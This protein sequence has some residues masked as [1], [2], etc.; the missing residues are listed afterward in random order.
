MPQ[1]LEI[2]W[3]EPT[4]ARSREKVARLLDTALDLAVETGSLDF[5]VTDVA[6]R[7]GVAIGTLYQFFPSRAALIARLFAREME[8]I[9]ESISALF[10]GK[11]DLAGLATKV[12]ALMQQQLEWVKARPGLSV[13]WTAPTMHPDIERADFE[14]TRRNA[15]TLAALLSP[16]L[17]ATTT[18][19]AIHATALLICH[20]W[21]SVIR[22]CVLVDDHE[23]ADIIRQYANMI[24]AHGAALASAL[25]E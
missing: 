5:K 2:V 20:L 1:D 15:A 19:E 17:P 25:G 23:Q 4:Q 14:N 24:I 16:H 18:P 7:A 3:N 10:D 8:P 11:L 12:P 6:K 21:S 9:D 13:I 22:L